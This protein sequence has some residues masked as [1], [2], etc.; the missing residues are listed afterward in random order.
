MLLKMIL[1]NLKQ[2]NLSIEVKLNMMML[3]GLTI[4]SGHWS[5]LELARAMILPACH[6]VAGKHHERDQGTR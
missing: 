1:M 4:L 5:F 3:L 2:M 6:S